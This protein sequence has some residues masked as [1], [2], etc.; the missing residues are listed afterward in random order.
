M[1]SGWNSRKLK[2]RRKWQNS[3][4]NRTGDLQS[5]SGLCR[6]TPSW[7]S[8]LFW[9]SRK[10]GLRTSP[11]NPYFDFYDKSPKKDRK[12][13]VPH[14]WNLNEDPQLTGMLTHFVPPG[15]FKG[16]NW[17]FQYWRS[18]YCNIIDATFGRTRSIIARLSRFFNSTKRW[19][20][21]SNRI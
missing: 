4:K 12:R 15:E 16:W 13:V 21:W 3:K 2:T 10:S 6:T 1:N 19:T 9:R 17:T 5:K 8:S 18:I 11:L 7:I 20:I 14:L